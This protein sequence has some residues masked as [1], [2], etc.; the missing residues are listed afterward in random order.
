ME[1]QQLF[2]FQKVAQYNNMSKAA[3]ELH[4]TQPALS[5]SIAGLENELGIQ[6]FHRN[7]KKIFLNEDGSRILSHVDC[8]L[9]EFSNIYNIASKVKQQKSVHI[10]ARA[11]DQLIPEMVFC[12]NEK[13]PEIKI[14]VSHYSTEKVPDITVTSS[15]D[16]YD[17]EDGLTV[18]KEDFVMVVPSDHALAGQDSVELSSLEGESIVILGEGIPLRDIILHWLNKAGVRV[19]FSYE[20]DSCGAMRELLNSGRGVGMVPSKTWAFPYNKS[21]KVIPIVNNDCYRYVNVVCPSL[22]QDPEVVKM[23]R[24]MVSYLEKFSADNNILNY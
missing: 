22:R 7:G 15:L 13:H 19:S 14:M 9:N 21:I 6:L 5:K 24:F 12:M 8:I 23:Y 10:L 16:E 11:A 2:N 18:L 1:R 3:R 4:I 17:G 20:C